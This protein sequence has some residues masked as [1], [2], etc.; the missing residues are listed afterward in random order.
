MLTG[1]GAEAGQEAEVG[2]GVEAGPT[3]LVSPGPEAEAGLTTPTPTTTTTLTTTTTTTTGITT[4][5]TGE[6]IQAEAKVGITAIQEAEAETV[7]TVEEDHNLWTINIPL[8]VNLS[9]TSVV[10]QDILPSIAELGKPTLST[11]RKITLHISTM[12]VQALQYK[13]ALL[14]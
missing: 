5:S 7:A 10:S 8:R 3:P 1:P 11:L 6:G 12:P 14:F 9:V 4:I 13:L 2:A